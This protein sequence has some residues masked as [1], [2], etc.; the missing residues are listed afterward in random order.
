MNNIQKHNSTSSET[1]MKARSVDAV[2]NLPKAGLI[3]RPCQ[4]PALLL[5]YDAVASILANGRLE[6]IIKPPVLR[7]CVDTSKPP[8]TSRQHGW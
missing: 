4:G 6:L 1:Y 7:P 8:G 2:T 5:R 3:L